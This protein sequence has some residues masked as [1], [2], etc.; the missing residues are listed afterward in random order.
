[1]L[2]KIFQFCLG[3]LCIFFCMVGCFVHET[4]TYLIRFEPLPEKVTLNGRAITLT[5]GDSFILNKMFGEHMLEATFKN[6]KKA[7][8]AV[9]PRFSDDNSGSM[10]IKEDGVLSHGD[11]RYKVLSIE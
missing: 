6:G 4:H 7:K 9:Y 10:T 5:D 11:L 3:L 2:V 1:M 8:I